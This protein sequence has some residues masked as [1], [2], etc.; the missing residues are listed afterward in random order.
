MSHSNESIN[1]DRDSMNECD[2]HDAIVDIFRQGYDIRD[3][4]DKVWK[5]IENRRQKPHPMRMRQTVKKQQGKRNHCYLKQIRHRSLLITQ[6]V[7]DKEN[8]CFKDTYQ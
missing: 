6:E 3:E 1:D 5:K 7:M 2:Q 8:V 4:G